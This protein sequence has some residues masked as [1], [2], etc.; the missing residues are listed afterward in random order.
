M[1]PSPRMR[2]T[3]S[4]LVAEL[5]RRRVFRALVGYGLGAFA[6]LQI[7]EPIM[8][9]L[10]WSEMVLS[11][12]VVALAVGFPIV[13]GLAWI[14][15]VNAGRI[16][17]S[18]PVPLTQGGPGALLTA[19]LIGIGL[20][21]AAPGLGWYFLWRGRDHSA[22]QAARA[23]SIAVLPFVNLSSDKEQEYFS[24]GLTE[25]ILDALAQVEGLHVAGRT[26]SFSFKGKRDDLRMIGQKL[27]VAHLLEGSVRREG[28]RV[29]VTAQLINAADGYHLWS[30]TFDREMTGV[31]A[32][33]DE[34]SRAV[35]EALKVRLMPGQKPR[36]RTVSPEVYNEYLLGKQFAQRPTLDD[37]RRAVAAYEKAIQLDPLFAPA[38]A[39]LARSK[40]G[41]ELS[42]ETPPAG[43]NEAYERG[44]A[45]A[46][47]AVALDPE[48]ADG[49]AA[50]GFFRAY[51]AEW[52]GARTDV[53]RALALNPGDA[54]IHLNYAWNILLP[55]GRL[56]DAIREA[57][58]ATDL[59]PL[60]DLAWSSLGLLYL[61]SG[62]LGPAQKASERSLRIL[63]EQ[64]NASVTLAGI[65]LTQKKPSEALAMAEQIGFEPL[66]LMIKACGLND[67][68]RI[69][70]SRQMV[71]QM[72]TRYARSGT[73]HI[74]EAYA[75][76]GD[77]DR[78]FEWL[79]RTYA[80][81]GSSLAGI[82]RVNPVFRSLHGD[83]RFAA[84]LK[85]MNLPME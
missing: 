69:E 13:V 84:L 10:H 51:K 78:A 36:Q 61:S 19:V 6:I 14:F 45:A 23:P 3:A 76:L 56:P 63:P 58:R 85:K 8:H 28:N 9:G 46:E 74:A 18:A 67:L 66:R 82:M 57:Q 27:E 21:A 1:L 44:M 30:K 11:Y 50:R 60:S 25:E 79:E 17:K 73:L 59:D 5:Q 48:L 35:V 55:L 26:S 65:L 62:Q 64:N 53:E 22:P 29:R 32:V 47:K 4:S 80:M 83:P 12:V 71:E 37:D 52:E 42:G 54:R 20:L 49:Y 31:F 15:D 2:G 70:E 43:I 34:I 16:E 41:L 68:G 75:C 24:D 33:E 40:F 39:S 81:R 7:V 72:I 77:R 38:W